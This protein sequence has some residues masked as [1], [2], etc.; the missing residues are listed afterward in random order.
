MEHIESFDGTRLAVQCDGPYEGP[1]IVFSHYLGGSIESWERQIPVFVDD[2]RIVR[3]DTRGQGRSDAP[4]GTYDVDMLGRDALA[5]MDALGLD[6]V[7]FVGV[8]QGG[9]AGMWLAIHHPGRIRRLVLANTTPFIP[10][11][12]IWDQN[13]AKALQEGMASIAEATISSWFSEG[14]KQRDPQR[15]QQAI[16]TMRA[17]T[18]RGYVGNCAVLRDVDLRD[19]LAQI[20]SPTL[21]IGGAEDGPRGA[22]APVIAQTVANGKLAVVPDAAHLTHIENPSAFNATVAEFLA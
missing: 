2:Y 1:P 20:Q 4:K 12:P 9:M 5:L 11:K 18:P 22:A 10:N 6:V 8:S 3:Y 19:G 21:V 17:M 13:S 7:D 15:V 14:F 16:A